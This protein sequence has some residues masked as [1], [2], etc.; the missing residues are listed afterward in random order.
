MR[1]RKKGWMPLIGECCWMAGAHEADSLSGPGTALIGA[2]ADASQMQLVK[3]DVPLSGCA[4]FEM[5]K[6][7]LASCFC[8]W[9]IIYLFIV[10]SAQL[11]SRCDVW[12]A[13][14]A[15]LQTVHRVLHAASE[16]GSQFW[17]VSSSHP[18]PHTTHSVKHGHVLGPACN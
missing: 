2:A 10:T 17:F 7:Q 3:Q 5:M 12:L 13:L 4:P 1:W 9:R 14:K 15:S 8:G 11:R 6:L 16:S 18:L